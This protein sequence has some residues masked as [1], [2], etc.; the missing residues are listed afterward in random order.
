[1]DRIVGIDLGTTNS[2]VAYLDGETP[3][4]I[5]DPATGRAIVP[6]VVAFR[7]DGT[8]L[9][10]DEARTLAVSEPATTNVNTESTSRATAAITA[11]SQSPMSLELITTK[12][13]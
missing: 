7:P 11:D 8:V 2:L 13:V 9:V 4:V 6:S 5:A 1:M 12:A 10:G 3:R